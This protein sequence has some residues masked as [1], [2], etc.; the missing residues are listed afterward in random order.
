MM[1]VNWIF[2][3]LELIIHFFMFFKQKM[4]RGKKHSFITLAVC[5]IWLY[6]Q[7]DHF[8]K[9]KWLGNLQDVLNFMSYSVLLPGEGVEVTTHVSHQYFWLLNHLNKTVL[10]EREKNNKGNMYLEL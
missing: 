7:W 10:K 4:S 5:V 1:W 8:E 9:V 2:Q 3:I 6:T